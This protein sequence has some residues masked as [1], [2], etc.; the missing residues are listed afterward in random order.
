NAGIRDAH[1]VLQ[2]LTG[3]EVLP[4]ALEVALHHDAED[5]VVAARNLL[6]N[7]VPDFDL[8]LVLL[9]AVAVAEVDHDVGSQ[10]G[11][12]QHAGS[13][14]DAAGVEVRFFA[15]PEDDVTVLVALRL[16]DRG[17]TTLGH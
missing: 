9:A 11:V 13:R 1:A 10:A 6:R 7:A 8:L 14:F 12:R 2:R 16:D 17:M 5:A 15:A 3:D 4:A